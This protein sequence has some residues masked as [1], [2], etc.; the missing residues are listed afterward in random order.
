MNDHGFDIFDIHQHMGSTGDAH[1]FTIEGQ[2]AAGD[3]DPDEL[4]CRLEFMRQAGIGRAVAIPGHNYNRADGIKSTRAE[5]DAIARYRDA[6]PDRFPIAVGV[7]EPL[8]QAAAL[9]E[10]TRIA[11]ELDL[12]GVS[13]HTEFQGVTIDSP[14][15][16]KILERMIDVGLVPLIHAS[17]VVLH[18]ALWR[19]AKVARAFPEV[20][21]VALEPFYTF[22]GMQQCFFFAELAPNIIFDTASC[23]VNGMMIEMAQKFGADRIIFGSQFYSQKR[24]GVPT[25]HPK[26]QLTLDE[27]IG[28][29]RLSHED[30]QKI[31]GL[32]TQRIFQT[33]S[34]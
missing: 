30:K 26:A 19:L 34:N 32:N 6:T 8:D 21:I 28:S 11:S 20:P 9:D 3:I 29:D 33:I 31:L 22:E 17:N 13:F 7:I 27:I 18:E 12:K 24:K 2:V 16:M 1:G 14:W 10:V 15:M 4:A 23:S 25:L 5:N